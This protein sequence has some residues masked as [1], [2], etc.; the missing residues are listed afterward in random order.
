MGPST[1]GKTPSAAA[2]SPTFAPESA[3]A[4]ASGGSAS[5]APTAAPGGKARHH[6]ARRVTDSRR[7]FGLVAG[8]CVLFVVATLAAMA[9]YPGGSVANPQGSGYSFFNNFFSDLGQTRTLSGA[10]N[11]A[12][13]ALF[14]TALI[15]VALGLGLFFVALA[16]LYSRRTAVCWARVAAF[17]GIVTGV[18]FLGVAATPWNLYLAAHNEFVHWAFRSFLGAAVAS[19]AAI[20][21]E[22]GFP[23]RF[24]SVF[25]G[26]ALILL[27]YVLLL[28]LGPK[29]NTPDG[30]RIQAVGQKIIVY[31]SIL[32]VLAQAIGLRAWLG[33]SRAGLQD[34]LGARIKPA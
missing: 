21:S 14:A 29:P 24:A 31:S 3:P 13:M 11:L 25:G 15:V 9:I 6:A 1:R 30:A 2:P 18:C 7:A 12:C 16:R 20:L 19:I 4:A 17:F 8:A 32:A 23:R 28:A 5:R 10:P 33:R 34:Q 22:T 27:A 26:F